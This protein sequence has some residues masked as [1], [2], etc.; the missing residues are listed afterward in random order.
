MNSYVHGVDGIAGSIDCMHYDWLKCPKAWQ[1]VFKRGDQKYA[2]L[3]LEAACDYNLY[4]WH[5]N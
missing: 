1:G 3:V 4:F 5:V 2:S